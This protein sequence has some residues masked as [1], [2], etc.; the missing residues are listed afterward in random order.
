MKI[1]DRIFNT[2]LTAT[3]L[4]AQ[5]ELGSLRFED[6]NIYKYVQFKDNVTASIGGPAIYDGTSNYKVTVDMSEGVTDAYAGV[7]LAT[8]GA[9][10]DTYAWIQIYGMGYGRTTDDIS[11]STRLIPTA[12]NILGAITT[13]DSGYLAMLME[14]NA[15]D[16]EATFNVFI[17]C[18]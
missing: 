2:V 15:T 8:Q 14:D 7:A 5:E 9:T 4:T 17:R 11:A 1:V 16:T 18:L 12:D 13:S 6:G 10:T 3:D